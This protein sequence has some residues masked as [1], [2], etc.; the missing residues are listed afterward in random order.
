DY[1]YSPLGASTRATTS[2]WLAD[3]SYLRLKHLAIGYSLPLALIKKIN[4]SKIRIYVSAENLLTFT[5]FKFGDPESGG[6]LSYP[7]M[8]SLSAG[9]NVQF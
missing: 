3:K 7:M 6:Q 4:V 5:K 9:L 8:R 2:F 1:Y